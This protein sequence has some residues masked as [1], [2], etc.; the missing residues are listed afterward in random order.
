MGFKFSRE[1]SFSGL[2]ENFLL[3]F[4]FYLFDHRILI[5]FHGIQHYQPVL[6]GRR[7]GQKDVET[8]FL[9]QQKADKIKETWAETNGY[10]LIVVPYTVKP[11]DISEYL[12]E[13]LKILLNLEQGN[14]SDSS[15]KL[16]GTETNPHS[17]PARPGMEL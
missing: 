17:V 14:R 15:D 6:F 3:H 5:E 1:V 7:M 2:R 9:A 8:V 4:D 10:T 16:A 12:N 13:K 11:Q